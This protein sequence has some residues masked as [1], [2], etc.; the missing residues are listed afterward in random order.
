[1]RPQPI[2]LL[3]AC[4]LLSVLPAAAAYAPSAFVP[5]AGLVQAARRRAGICQQLPLRTTTPAG[6]HGRADTLVM[7]A[8]KKMTEAQRKALAALEQ[9]EAATSDGPVDTGPS[10]EEEE[11]ARKRAEKKAK[12]AAKKGKGKGKEASPSQAEADS[13]PAPDIKKEEA[14]APVAAEKAEAQEAAPQ[15]QAVTEEISSPQ[16][17]AVT[18]EISSQ[19]AAVDEDLS[20]LGLDDDGGG[21]PKMSKKKQGKK[22]KKG[23]GKTSDDS[24]AEMTAEGA[25][26]GEGSAQPVVAGETLEDKARKGRPAGGR[27][28]I[29]SNVQPGYVR[30]A[31]EK[32]SVIFKNQEVLSD[33]TWQVQTGDRVGLVGAN[34]GGK[35]TQLRILSGDLE[36]TTGDVVKSAQDLKLGFLRQEFVDELVRPRGVSP[37]PPPQR[38][39]AHTL[40]QHGSIAATL[41]RHTH[42]LDCSAGACDRV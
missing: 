38:C 22:G 4:A 26:G 11:K 39:I 5:A 29:D 15:K 24:A 6:R 25:M 19:V 2:S 10:P 23:K 12:L 28:K 3:A 34:G 33:A 36:P 8:K 40:W 7:M 9:F 31:L 14:P 27:I 32:V 18:E 21:R 1:M 37:C 16:K 41:T 17:Q 35:T 13:A 30:L 42:A 20:F